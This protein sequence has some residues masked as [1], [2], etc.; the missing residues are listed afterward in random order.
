VLN[1][2][3]ARALHAAGITKDA[4]R[5]RLWALARAPLSWYT[6]RARE[7]AGLDE[8]AI[9]DEVPIADR[10]EDIMIVVAGAD[11]WHATFVPTYGDSLAVTTRVGEAGARP[12]VPGGRR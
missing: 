4:L 6:K 1:P 12:E 10:P 7:V 8:R 5:A 9:R 11:G 3:H 2:A